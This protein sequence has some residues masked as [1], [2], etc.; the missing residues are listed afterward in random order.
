MA[1]RRADLVGIEMMHLRL[2]DYSGQVTEAHLAVRIG[3]HRD[4][5]SS[6]H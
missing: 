6:L 5:A 4:L 1:P 3:P 2:A